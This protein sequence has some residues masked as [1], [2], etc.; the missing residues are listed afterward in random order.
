[1]KKN[2]L[3]ICSFFARITVVTLALVLFFTS[4]NAQSLVTWTMD[5]TNQYKPTAI[6]ANV[7]AGSFSADAAFGS[8][9]SSTTG[10]RLKQSLAWPTVTPTTNTFNVD[11]PISPKGNNDIILNGISVQIPGTNIAAG[12]IL[13]MTPYYQIDGAGSWV[14]IAP[15]QSIVN[16]TPS[17]TFSGLTQP[18]YST[19]SYVVRMYITTS[20]GATKNEYFYI[21]NVV[22]SGTTTSAA[23]KPTVS[24]LTA[25]KSVTTPKYAGTA[26]GTYSTGSGFQ[27]VTQS[28]V[29]WTTNPSILPDATLPTKT[30]D[31][32]NGI[33]NSNITGLSVATTYYVEP[34]QL[35]RL[36]RYTAPYYLLQQTQLRSLYFLQILQLIFFQTKQLLVEIYPTMGAFLSYRKGFVGVPPPAQKQLHLV[37]TLPR[38]AQVIPLLVV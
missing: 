7:T 23:A 38:T 26:T 5:K 19:H 33:I 12:Q 10:F 27:A 4:T 6:A 35:H 31:G 17:V 1:M 20:T 16:G 37:L 21:W 9:F 15:A 22:L 14:Q 8:S 3:L 11:F 28:G 36:I 24:T 18:F 32:S 2:S 13:L 25:A 34:M 30:T 29:C